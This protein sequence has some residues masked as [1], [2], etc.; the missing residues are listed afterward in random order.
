MQ[1]L[2]RQVPIA[3]HVADYA[4]RI[5]MATHPD[6]EGSPEPTT[7]FVRYGASPRAAQAIVLAAK[8]LAL[9]N[10]RLNVSFEDVRRVAPPALRHRMLLNFEA[11]AKSITPD[12]LIR[13]VLQAIPEGG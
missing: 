13:S 12:T 5:V 7:R 4:V 8:I 6:L 11:E 3:S 2:A 9:L 1:A 10:G